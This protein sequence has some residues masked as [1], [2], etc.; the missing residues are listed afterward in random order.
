MVSKTTIQNKVKNLH[1]IQKIF[2][3]FLDDTNLL[4]T[5]NT[6]LFEKEVK[7]K[8][9]FFLTAIS[10]F[11]STTIWAAPFMSP[12]IGGSTGLISTPTAKTGWEDAAI[13]LDIGMHYIQ[14]DDGDAY[15]LAVTLQLFNRWELGGVFDIQEDR[16]NDIIGHTKLN[17][18]NSGSS[19][20][21]IGGNYQD[22]KYNEDDDE[23]HVFYQL[24]LAA[25]YGGKFFNMPAQTTI[26]FGK[27][28]G[29]DVEKKNIDFSMGFDLDFFPS[30][31][32]GYVHWINDFANYSYSMDPV[33]AESGR[34]GCFNTGIRIA[35]F[36]DKNYKLNFDAILTDALD[37]NRAFALGAAFG[38]AI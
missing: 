22:L 19:A 4:Y 35:V 15:P 13:G 32:K 11:L 20:L 30:V 23:D 28:F 9:I 2:S 34:R 37:E 33:G 16:G 31:F 1:K 7:M 24:Y 14:D 26:V 25:T 18:Y 6:I 10:I 8:K 17:F 38:L 12:Q 27:T 36:R 3:Y 21:A 5:L 29:D